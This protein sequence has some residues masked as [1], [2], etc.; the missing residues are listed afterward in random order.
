MEQAKT[1]PTPDH[2]GTRSAVEIVRRTAGNPHRD[3]VA[4]VR[5]SV[6]IGGGGGG[7]W[8]QTLMIQQVNGDVLCV[9]TKWK[10]RVV[11]LTVLCFNL[12]GTP[13]FF[14]TTRSK[15]K[16]QSE[17]KSLHTNRD[18]SFK[19]TVSALSSFSSPSIL[20]TAYFGVIYQQQTMPSSNLFTAFAVFARRCRNARSHHRNRTTATAVAR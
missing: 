15:F 18:A 3:P 14:R 13:G 4:A 5:T 10:S 20:S 6:C 19:S 12:S 17:L 11:A 1:F 8:V 2:Q 9:P 7:E 16:L